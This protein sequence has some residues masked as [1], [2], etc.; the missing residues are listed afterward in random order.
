MKKIHQIQNTVAE[1]YG[2]SL[3]RMLSPVRT[4]YITRARHVAMWLARKKTCASLHE[5]GAAFDRDH[6]TVLVALRKVDQMMASD[7][8]FREEVENLTRIDDRI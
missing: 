1:H 4:K 6:T 2:I 8:S 7:M 5:I 3:G